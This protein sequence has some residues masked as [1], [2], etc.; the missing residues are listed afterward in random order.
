MYS[1]SIAASGST[2]RSADECEMSRSCHSATFCI[3]VVTCPRR[4]RERPV[5][6]S[7]EMGLRLCGIAELPFWPL[8]KPSRTSPTSV[9]CRCRNSTAI[10]SIVVPRAAQAVTNSA[11]RSRAITCV[12]GTGTSPSALAT[13][14]S[15]RGSMFEYVP[16]APDNL[17]T[18][19]A[20]LAARRRRRSRSS[21]SAHNANFAPNVVGSACMP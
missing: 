9:R 15:T 5:N 21:C 17:H 11:W 1:V 20:S 6:V 3:A 2:I 14:C 16:T 12:A 19:T 13:C 8:P 7:A 10:I 18:A 4:T